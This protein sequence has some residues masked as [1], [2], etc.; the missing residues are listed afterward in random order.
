MGADPSFPV[1][2]V[3]GNGS[4]HCPAPAGRWET[5]VEGKAPSRSFLAWDRISH[6]MRHWAMR[7]R[8]ARDVTMTRRKIHQ[9]ILFGITIA[10]FLVALGF[11]IFKDR[12]T[13]VFAITAVAY[14][15]ALG[16]LSLACRWIL[17]RDLLNRPERPSEF[18]QIHLGPVTPAVAGL[19][20]A[21]DVVSVEEFRGQ[22]HILRRLDRSF[23]AGIWSLSA[24]ESAGEIIA[25][26]VDFRSEASPVLDF[27]ESHG[28]G[29]LTCLP[30]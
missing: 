20:S 5:A 17:P 30:S 26:A 14:L 8:N 24:E 10:M 18:L 19:L 11:W 15:A 23:P 6:K 27:S 7:L 13:E 3:V 22:E 4:F 21:A 28:E 1:I 29:R 25:W 16:I 9:A 2:S 12:R